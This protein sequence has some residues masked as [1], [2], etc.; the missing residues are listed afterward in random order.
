[1][2]SEFGRAEETIVRDILAPSAVIVAGH[3][4]YMVEPTD[5]RVLSG[6]L[7]GESAASL[8]LALTGGVRLDVL[9]KDIKSLKSLD[10]S[11][12]PESLAVAL[13]PSDVANVIAW[14]RQPPTRQVLFDD[15]HPKKFFND[16]IANV[17]L[18]VLANMGADSDGAH[19]G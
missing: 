5:E 9:R 1:M 14:L 11:L 10:V 12:M 6:V 4:T 18:N 17:Y 15:I 8:T 16:A 2:T 3:E 13:K 7:A 19:D